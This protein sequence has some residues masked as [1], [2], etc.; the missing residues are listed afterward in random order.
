MFIRG[1][2]NGGAVLGERARCAA[3]ALRSAPEARRGAFDAGA[4][5]AKNFARR[6]GRPEDPALRRGARLSRRRAQIGQA[7]GDRRLQRRLG[8]TG[9]R[10]VLRERG[11]SDLRRWRMARRSTRC[12]ARRWGWRSCRW[13]RASRPTAWSCS[14]SRTSSATG[15]RGRR[16]AGATSTSS[17]P[18]RRASRRATSSST[19]STASAA[20]RGWRRS[21]SAAR[22]TIASRCSMPA[23]TGC[24]CRSRTSRCC[25]ATARRRPGAQLDRLGGAAWQG[26]KAR[27]KQRI[28]E[29]AGEL[30]RVAAE[31]AG[32]AGRGDPA[33]RG[34]LRG[35]R[36]ALPLSRDRGPAARDRGHAGRYGR[37]ASRWTG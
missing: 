17:S 14:A 18:R 4:R 5:P 23:T 3:V 12:R 6:A 28:R 26:R 22:R 8:A 27:V 32:A 35:I 29:I 2:R 33:A 9:S 25:R 20:T 1:R 24:S 11:L 30:I 36:R 31:R 34:H 10:T 21:M 19:R 15:W 13:S 16:G 37:R 7:R